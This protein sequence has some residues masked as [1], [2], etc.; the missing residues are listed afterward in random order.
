MI[1]VAKIPGWMRIEPYDKKEYLRTKKLI[2]YNLVTVCVEA[3]C[4]NRYECFSK[5][6]ATFMILGDTCTRNCLY[7][8]IKSGV[9]A[10]VDADEPARIARAIKKLD[11]EYSVI[12]CVTRDDLDDGGAEQF[13]KTVHEIRKIDPH[14]KIELLISDLKGNLDALKRIVDV[15]PDVLNHNIEAVKNLFPILRPKGDYGLSLQLLKKAKEF[16]PELKTKSGFML[17]F[18]EDEE[19]IIRTLKDL[20]DAGCDIVTIGQYLQPSEKH[21]EVKKYYAKEEFSRIAEKAKEL[22]I[23]QVVAGPLVRSSYK[24][25]EC[26]NENIGLVDVFGRLKNESNK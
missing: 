20:N 25:R 3:N 17:G 18:G 19:Q 26:Y 12:T 13:V 6:T 15:K 7:C 24:A 11:L 5:R 4:P 9:S 1:D 10:E 21:F 2:N 16:S 22:G 8:N 14:C 23:K